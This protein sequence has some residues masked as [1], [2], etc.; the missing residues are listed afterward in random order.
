MSASN[1]R[2][3][4][5]VLF[6]RFVDVAAQRGTHFGPHLKK[7]LRADPLILFSGQVLFKCEMRHPGNMIAVLFRAKIV[8]SHAGMAQGLSSE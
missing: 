2:I 8:S 5:T 6:K 3:T 7:S 4:D 1:P